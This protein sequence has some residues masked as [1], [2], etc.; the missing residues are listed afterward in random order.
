MPL[1]RYKPDEKPSNKHYMNMVFGSRGNKAR[2]TSI[3]LNFKA[4][5]QL[6]GE[7]MVNI[8]K[9]IYGK[10]EGSKNWRR[11]IEVG[12]FALLNNSVVSSRNEGWR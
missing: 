11:V 7:M 8:I 3:S 9:R 2:I 5:K 6:L 1:R 4:Q 12:F 10:V